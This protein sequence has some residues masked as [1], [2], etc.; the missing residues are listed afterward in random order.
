MKNLVIKR[1]AE[2]VA[3]VIGKGK[4][5][6][7][8]IKKDGTFTIREASVNPRLMAKLATG[9]GQR[10]T[11]PDTHFLFVDLKENDFRMFLLENIVFVETAH[12]FAA[13]DD[14]PLGELGV[15]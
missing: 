1:N 14:S 3:K 2:S 11:N 15:R 9:R 10:N 8:A 6:V 4:F 12:Q 13:F 7:G 5:R